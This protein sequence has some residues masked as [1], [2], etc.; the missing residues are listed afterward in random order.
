MPTKFL[1][2]GLGNPGTQYRGT[3]HNF[4]AAAVERLHRLTANTKCAA[5]TGSL[6]AGVRVAVPQTFMNESG[7]AVSKLVKYYRIEPADVWLVHDD[8]DLPLGTIRI[9]FGSSSGGHRGVASAIEHLG[10]KEFWR[11]RLGIGSQT[12]GRTP[13][14][15][16]VLQRFTN[17]EQL[18][19]SQVLSLAEQTVL[20]S[21][22]AGTIRAITTTVTH[23][24]PA[25]AID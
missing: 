16:Y 8:I 13:T 18:A 25:E 9:S 21:I 1:L 3:R 14:E 17:G 2:V 12:R 6:A 23:G 11:I 19:V 20:A 10:T 5:R 7:L 24:H 22:A 4:G 15:Q